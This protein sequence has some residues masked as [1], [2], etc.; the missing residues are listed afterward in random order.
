M[1]NLGSKI[2]KTKRLTLR[3]FRKSDAEAMFFNWAS[4]PLVTKYMTWA[5]HKSVE[6]SRARCAFC[7]E[8]SKK[9]NVYHW[10]IERNGELIGDIELGE[11]GESETGNVGYCLARKYWGQGFM[12]EALGE[13]VRF[14]FE[15]VG[16]HRI[17]GM[18]VEQNIGSSRV[19]E[20]CGLKYEGLKRNGFRLHSSGEWVNI[21]MRGI[22]REDYF[23]QK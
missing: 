4:D 6:E 19:M 23:R 18:H 22:L 5:P 13:V 9:P 14:A 10:A 21:V 12:T 15:E 1:Q 20:K 3:P 11:I 7:E 2:L 8:E 17:D 16:L